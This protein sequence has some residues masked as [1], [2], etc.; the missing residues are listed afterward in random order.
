MPVLVAFSGLMLC[1]AGLF[2][3]VE[4]EMVGV[5][6]FI[7]G[8]SLAFTYMGYEIDFERKRYKEFISL[9]GIRF[10]F[11][12]SLSH[13]DFIFVR[14]VELKG[15][16]KRIVYKVFLKDREKQEGIELAIMKT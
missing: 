9:A 3:F 12:Q 13:F 4:G 15:W 2:V 11:W 14:K 1:I 8:L 7:M 6:P 5:A 10:G 16:S